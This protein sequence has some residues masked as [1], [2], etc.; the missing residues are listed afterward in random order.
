MKRYSTTL[1]ILLFVVTCAF[2]LVSLA[3][4]KGR[5]PAPVVKPT[6]TPDLRVEAGQVA[7]Q[8]KNFSK[9]IYIYGKVVNGFELADDQARSGSMTPAAA[10]K[11][12]E[13]K[14]ALLA[15]VRNLK[16]GVEN[17]TQ[18]FRNNP[19]LQVYALKLSFAVDAAR[20][21]ERLATGGRYDDA[22]KSLV[23]VIERLTDTVL[24]M[25]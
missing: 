16:V 9:F 2:P 12:R 8:I 15:N 13:S 17:L 23:T 14:E 4:R 3:Q 22:G 18:S 5:K 1:L 25:R 7:D 20:D 10:A 24:S 21:A 11:N 19:R 6:P